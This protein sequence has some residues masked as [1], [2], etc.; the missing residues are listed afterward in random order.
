LQAQGADLLLSNS[1]EKNPTK[2]WDWWR[3]T[4][5]KIR[6]SLKIKPSIFPTAEDGLTDKPDRIGLNAKRQIKLIM[7]P[8]TISRLA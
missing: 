5:V 6:N 4:V 8:K 1:P 2:V 7:L 3:K